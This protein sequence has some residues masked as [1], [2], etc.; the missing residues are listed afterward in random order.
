MKFLGHIITPH[1]IRPDPNNLEAIR[2]IP[3]PNTIKELQSFLGSIN[4]Y[5]E[6]LA[7]LCDYAEPLQKLTRQCTSKILKI[8]E[9]FYCAFKKIK[10][11]LSVMR[12]DRRI[13]A[14]FP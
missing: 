14:F 12:S 11:M 13:G 9:S 6:F 8:V 5:R 2:Q 4:Y 3:I 7:H 10:T 1:S